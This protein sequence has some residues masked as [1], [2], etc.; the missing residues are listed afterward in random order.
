MGR[1]MSR[2]HHVVLMEDRHP[3]GLAQ[4]DATVPVARQ[5][6]PLGIDRDAGAVA[7]D[8]ADDLQGLVLGAVVRD[9]QVERDP[10][11]GLDRG[12]GLAEVTGPV[13]GG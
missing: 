10:F 13:A 6:Q 2:T 7:D 8:P 5:A 3:F 11:L 9:D 12:Q 1:Q 4:L